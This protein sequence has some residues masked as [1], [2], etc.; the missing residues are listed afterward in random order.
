MNPI[1]SVHRQR[2]VRARPP[3]RPASSRRRRRIG[4][5]APEPAVAGPPAREHRMATGEL[6]ERGEPVGRHVLGG[7][8]RQPQDAVGA[9]VAVHQSAVPVEPLGDAEPAVEYLLNDAPALDTEIERGA[10]HLGRERQALARGVAPR[11][12]TP[13]GWTEET[14]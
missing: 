11:E 13:D 14:V 4:I 7:P 6:C 2:V 9:T 5:E 12:D 1:T 10:D 3:V 8:L